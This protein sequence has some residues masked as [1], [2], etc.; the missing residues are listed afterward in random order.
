MKIV[1]LPGVGFQEDR[2]DEKLNEYLSKKLGAEVIW[3]NWRHELTYPKIE[4]SYNFIRKWLSEVIFDFQFS[5]NHAHDIDI[6]KADYYIGHSAGSLI[7]AIK[8]KPCILMGSPITLIEEYQ[9]NDV[10]QAPPL[11]TK[12]VLNIINTYDALAYPS[13][14]PY[15]INQFVKFSWYNPIKAHTRYF[16]NKNV[17]RAIYKQIKYWEEHK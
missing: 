3:Y 1:I 8:D 2:V 6:P 4:L 12:N 11:P 13:T 5:I 14:L 17:I 10:L 15:I 16:N 7:A 9:L